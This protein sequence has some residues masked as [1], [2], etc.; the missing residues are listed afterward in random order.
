LPARILVVEDNA[1]IRQLFDSILRRAGYEIVEASDGVEAVEKLETAQFDL[2]ITD[3]A[4]PRA[5]GLQVIKWVKT[6]GCCPVVATTAHWQQGPLTDEALAAGCDA[7]LAKPFDQK[8]L[9][10]LVAGQI[11]ARSVR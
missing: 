3:L 2:V 1:A 5:S 7:L 11:T 9:L 4:L 6:K 8:Q 10:D